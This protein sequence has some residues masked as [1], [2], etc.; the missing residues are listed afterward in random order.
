VQIK[1]PKARNLLVSKQKDFNP[2]HNINREKKKKKIV[3]KIVNILNYNVRSF[4]KKTINSYNTF[5]VC[6]TYL[7]QIL[8]VLFLE[9]TI[10]TKH[11]LSSSLSFDT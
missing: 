5:G 11:H 10:N 1:K 8:K 3:K 9:G 2:I 4:F 6:K 7:S